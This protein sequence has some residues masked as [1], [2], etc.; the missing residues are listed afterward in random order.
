[1]N[2]NQSVSETIGEID[3]IIS[4]AL[5]ADS[6]PTVLV[7][8]LIPWLR[9]ASVDARVESLGDQLEAYVDQL[10]IPRVK[11]VDVR[12]GYRPSMMLGDLIHPNSAGEK[13]IADRFFAMYNNSGFCR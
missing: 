13:H 1:M 9:D 2:G 6:T 8:N 3:Q 10:N 11:I 12:T 4:I 7:A 5:A